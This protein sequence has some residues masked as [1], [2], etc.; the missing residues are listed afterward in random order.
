VIPHGTREMAR[1]AQT[2][3][4]IRLPAPAGTEAEIVDLIADALV[5]DGHT[6]RREVRLPRGAGRVDLWVDDGIVVEVKRGKPNTRTLK[7][8]VA[9][10]ARC[11][12]V[13]GVI[14]ASERGLLGVH[15]DTVDGTPVVYVALSA[16]WG[17]A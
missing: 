17:V 5:A 9:R 14:I 2:I 8:Q 11:V 1:A 10:Y 4:A 16:A 3:R 13:R 7:Q 15:D 12:R 6:V